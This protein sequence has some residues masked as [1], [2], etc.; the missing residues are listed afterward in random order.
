MAE[1]L[2]KRLEQIFLTEYDRW[3]LISYSYLK[4]LSEAEEVVQDVCAKIL[5]REAGTEILN[6]SGYI[7]TAVRNS[8]LNKLKEQKKLSTLTIDS[9]PEVY[10]TI[11][12]FATEDKTLALRKAI[13]NLPEPSKHIFQKCV[14]EGN[15]YQSVASTLN[16]SKNTVKYHIKKCYRLLRA[17]IADNYLVK[18]II[19]FFFFM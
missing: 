18:S 13:T 10:D 19:L 12:E 7:A 16:I 5:F 2:N 8:S 1:N 17:E 9:V 15:K 4:S 6:L 3:C 14:L 11:E